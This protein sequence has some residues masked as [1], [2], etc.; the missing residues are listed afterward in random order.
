[1]A[2]SE[3]LIHLPV[4][5]HMGCLQF[6]AAKNKAAMSI[7]SQVFAG[8]FVFRNGITEWY[9]KYMFVRNCSTFSK[10]DVPFPFCILISNG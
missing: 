8:K 10:M 9:R 5:E 2:S 7:H 3:L 4:G 6:G 1:M